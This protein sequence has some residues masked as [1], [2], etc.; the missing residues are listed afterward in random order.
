M[1]DPSNNAVAHDSVVGPPRHL[2]WVGG[3]RWS[4]MH[5]HM[6]SVSG[7]VSANGRLFY[8]FDEGARAAIELPPKWML[9]ARDA[10]NG[11]ILWKRPM[12][13]WHTHLW[14]L[15]SGPAHLPRRIVAVGDT[16]YATLGIDAPVSAF[17]AATGKTI[18]TYDGTQATEEI[19]VADGVL[20]LVVNDNPV[21]RF[22]PPAPYENIGQIKS[23]GNRRPWSAEPTQV[24]AVKADTG[25]I[26]WKKRSVTV[27]LTLA[28]GAKGVYF[29]NGERVVALDRAGGEQLWASDPVARCQRIL[30]SFAPTLVVYQDVVL[31][32]GGE[33][34]IPHRGGDDTM[35][36]LS[37]ETGKTLWSAGHGPTGYQS[38]ED[39]LV[40][41][42]LV[43]SGATTSGGMSGTFTG[44]DPHTGEVKK[45]FSPDVDTYWFHHRCYR[46][47]A[48]D[49]YL[50]M[51]RTGIVR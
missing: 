45:E 39:L 27:P 50:L 47:K 21:K 32:A 28:V 9:I 48:T 34:Y 33:K 22:Q 35:T 23:D 42:G 7:V 24:I 16:L 49:K 4:R 30:S 5:D 12:Q 15:K 3:P 51:L 11:T 10:F 18:R 40:A 41:E 46:G 6:S 44:L 19:I 1:H 26:L 43:W 31:C 29:H 13:Q 2:Q 25:E 20:F 8:I 17:D 38:P 36:A 14:P 37:A